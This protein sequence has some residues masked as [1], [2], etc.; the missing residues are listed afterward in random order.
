[1][2]LRA[3]ASLLLI[4]AYLD[5]CT[6]AECQCPCGLVPPGT[7]I[8]PPFLSPR[9]FPSGKLICVDGMHRLVSMPL[10]ACTSLLRYT[11]FT[12]EIRA[13]AACQ[14]PC[15]LVLHCYTLYRTIFDKAG[16]GGVNALAGLCHWGHLSSHRSCPHGLLPFLSPWS[17]KS[18]S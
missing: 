6:P 17:S 1:M 12:L 2:P 7:L 3:Y 16:F 13:M 15:G 4:S 5:M 10:R 14:C 18:H 8:Q 11:P 9:L